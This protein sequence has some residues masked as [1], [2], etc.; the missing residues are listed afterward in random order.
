MGTITCRNSE[1]RHIQSA[2]DPGCFVSSENEISRK[3]KVKGRKSKG[4][5]YGAGDPG[6]VDGTVT[7]IGIYH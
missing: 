1:I 5:E 2:L 3:S 6:R 7:E 4:G